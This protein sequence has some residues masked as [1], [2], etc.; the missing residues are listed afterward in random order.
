MKGLKA[1][2]LDKWIEKQEWKWADENWNDH[3]L[4]GYD[5][6]AHYS[7]ASQVNQANN[8]LD[9]PEAEDDDSKDGDYEDA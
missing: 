4:D 8:V 9:L 6:D 7:I 1:E 3:F 5:S 2:P